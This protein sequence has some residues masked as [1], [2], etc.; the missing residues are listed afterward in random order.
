VSGEENA[1]HETLRRDDVVKGGSDRSFGIVFAAV[2]GAIGVVKLLR[3][4]PL[5]WAWLAGACTFLAVALVAPRR[6]APANRLWLK[7]GLALHH[8]VEPVVMSVL[9]FVAVTPMGVAMR[10][11]GKDPL[12]LKWDRD[13][14]SYWTPRVPP[15]PAAESIRQQF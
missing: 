11:M 6:L 12:R 4:S 8:V 14:A 1:F 9:F 10:L 5:G 13:A 3:G 15:G 7:L 2:F